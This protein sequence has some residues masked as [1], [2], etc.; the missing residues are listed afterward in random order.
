M[1]GPRA[2][3]SRPFAAIGTRT[4]VRAVLQGQQHH[5]VV[6]LQDDVERCLCMSQGV[7]GQFTHDQSNV[8][9][10]VP[11]VVLEEMEADEVMCS[12]ALVASAASTVSC[13]HAEH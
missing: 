1:E 12:A 9:D 6:F 10:Q 8:L 11:Q 4:R 13:D 2:P 3:V 5:L 7:G